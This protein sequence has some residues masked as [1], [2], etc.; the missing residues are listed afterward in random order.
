MSTIKLS[1][2]TKKKGLKKMAKSVYHR[3]YVKT[4][5]KP[6]RKYD[7]EDD[8]HA[9]TEGPL[10][11]ARGAVGEIGRKVGGMVNDVSTA[12]RTTS[13]MAD[14][15]LQI[16][17][18]LSSLATY[19]ELKKSQQAEQQS[20][21][22]DRQA[23]QPAQANEQ[24]QQA[25][26]QKQKPRMR[27]G[28]YGMEYVFSS[29]FANL[30][31]GAA[32]TEGKWDYVKGA[33]GT[34]AS[35]LGNKFTQRF[36]QMPNWMKKADAAGRAA[37]SAA[38]FQKQRNAAAQQEQA[39]QR[40]M[41]DTKGRIVQLVR[42]LVSV[43]DQLTKYGQSGDTVIEQLTDQL[44]HGSGPRIVALMTRARQMKQQRV[45]PTM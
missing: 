31:N 4:K 13:L 28:P 33:V 30:S 26:Q 23:S 38:D 45:E 41:A 24:P 12:G 16:S 15:K 18:L 37:S 7:P 6:Y 43:S 8:K 5:N 9:L 3:D 39:Q 42:S 27:P 40:L 35:E 25:Q 17:R 22:D 20:V 1:E 44:N 29:E 19:D 21:K 10:D 34:A 11:F 2:A 14:A 32:L 36:T